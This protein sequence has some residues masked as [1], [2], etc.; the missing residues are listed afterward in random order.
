[1]SDNDVIVRLDDRIRLL[2][3]V[4]AATDYP[5]EAQKTKPHGTHAHAR[6]TRKY[7][8]DHADH[9]AVHMTQALLD[10]ETPLEAMFALVMLMDWPD[11]TAGDLPP[12]APAGY[13]EQLAMFR[14]SSRIEA[15]WAQDQ[16][17]ARWKSAQAEATNVFGG[18]L[19]FKRFLSPFLG[20]IDKTMVFIPNISYP[21][22]YDIGFAL[23]DELICIAPPPLA[24]G[25]SPPWPYDEAT[26]ITHSFK[27]ALMTYANI[28]LKAYLDT[29]ADALTDIAKEDLPLHE[30]FIAQYP[31]WRE[32]FSTLFLS[33][34]IAMYLEEHVDDKE[35]KAYML[36]EKKA[37]GLVN[38]PGTVSVMRRYLQ[39]VGGGKYDNLIEFLPFFP[40]QLR[41]AQKIVRF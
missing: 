4:I 37:N 20:A 30:Q 32:Q 13:G 2:S 35:Y 8:A 36:M 25:E 15:F 7:I 22:N 19:E 40:K 6:A 28:L 18:D 33:G 11:M 1:M 16:E 41:V 23:G 9:P 3:A 21:T 26:M 17:A 39:E 34:A 29:H 10:N 12:W 31:T 27:T 5:D 38:L 24:W 14:E